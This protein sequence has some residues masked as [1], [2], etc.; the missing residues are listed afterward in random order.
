VSLRRR[1]IRTEYTSGT[2]GTP[3]EFATWTYNA[4]EQWDGTSRLIICLHGHGQPG[5]DAIG[6]LAFNQNTG[7]GA[8][9]MALARTGRYVICSIQAAGSAAWSKQA[10]LDAINAAVIAARKRGVRPGKYGIIGWSMGGLTLAN[11]VKRDFANIAAAWEWCGA[12]DLDFVFSTAGHVPSSG[13][14]TWGTEATAAFGSYAASAGFRVWDEPAAYRNLGVKW[15]ICHATNDSV[16]PYSISADFVAA[17]ADPN[18]SL[19]APDVLGDHTG[20]FAYIPDDEVVAHFD[21]GVWNYPLANPLA[22]QDGSRLTN[23]SGDRLVLEGAG[24]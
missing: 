22:A 14:A 9:P 17:V 23:Q 19:R 3:G 12:K 16:I 8:A 11:Q 5:Q 24:T 2:A 4:G 13:N 15:K 21:S 20:L 10:A 18:V 7:P 6:S 1:S